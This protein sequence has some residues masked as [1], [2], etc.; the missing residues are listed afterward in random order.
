MTTQPGAVLWD[1]DGTIVNSDPLWARAALELCAEYNTTI[2]REV[3]LQ[4]V[5][6][7]LWKA[8]EVLQQH[9]VALSADE[10]VRRKVSRVLELYREMEISWCAGAPE[11]LAQVHRA[12]IP[13]YMVTMALTSIGQT[14]A[15]LLPEG[16]FT[17]VLGADQF[18]EHEHKP[19]PA[20]YL[21][22]AAVA[23]VAIADCL[24]FEDSVSGIAAAAASGAVTVGVRNLVDISNCSAH[25]IVDSLQGYTLDTWLDVFN[26]Y[27]GTA[28]VPGG[29]N[30]GAKL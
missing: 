9:G 21:K 29:Y 1:M 16:T 19:H 27:R 23:N 25:V 3:G 15:A 17:G 11:L 2:T 6:V 26:Q 28:P 7:S 22:A 4:M 5:G 30:Q 8:A 10:I 18:A 24:V 14:V 12:G 20:P 13:N